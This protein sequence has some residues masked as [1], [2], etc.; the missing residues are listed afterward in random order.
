MR[1]SS[2]DPD[3]RLAIRFNICTSGAVT[4]G[5]PHF[6]FSVWGVHSDFRGCCTAAWALN[7]RESRNGSKC[8]Y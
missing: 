2:I 1:V 5:D 7:R 8:L 6:S 3:V 4:P